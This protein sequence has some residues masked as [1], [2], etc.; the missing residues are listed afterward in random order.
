MVSWAAERGISHRRGCQL[1][2]VARFTLGRESKQ[3]RKDKALLISAY[4][5]HYNEQ[6]PHSSLCYQTP[7]E[8]AAVERNNC[9]S[10]TFALPDKWGQG[11]G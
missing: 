1:L 8:V 4:R 3:A 9:Q 10:L 7:S 2:N 6:R 11:S 5:R